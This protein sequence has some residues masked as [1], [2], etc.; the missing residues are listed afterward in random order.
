MKY[1]TINSEYYCGVDVHPKRSYVCVLDDMGKQHLNINIKNNFDTFKEIINPFLP[2]IVVGCESTYSYYWL[3][4]G[5]QQYRIPFYLG[6][7]LYMKAITWNKYKNDK[8]EAKSNAE[9]LRSSFFPEAYPY[10]R[11]MRPTRDSLR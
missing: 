7:A 11:E 4:D 8:L 1:W 6:H 3:F 2:N 5:C 10:P 9:L